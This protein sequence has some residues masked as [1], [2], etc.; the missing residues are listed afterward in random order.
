[1]LLLLYICERVFSRFQ[2]A[3]EEEEVLDYSSGTLYRS[4]EML[5]WVSAEREPA[6]SVSAAGCLYKEYS[7][8]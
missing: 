7:L 4:L 5:H 8:S 6:K 1:M 2:T 3:R